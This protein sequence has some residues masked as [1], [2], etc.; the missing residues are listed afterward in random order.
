MILYSTIEAVIKFTPNLVYNR[1]VYSV[2]CKLIT[3]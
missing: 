3:I 1:V 2:T